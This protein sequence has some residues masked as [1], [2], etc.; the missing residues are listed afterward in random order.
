MHTFAE[1][2]A[3]YREAAACFTRQAQQAVAARGRFVVAL[4][5]G[6]T[7]RGLYA[8]LAGAPYRAAVAWPRTH[9]FW[10]DERCVPAGDS[11]R[12]ARM[13]R[14]ALLDHVPVPPAQVHP[15]ECAADPEQAARQYAAQLRDFFA[16]QPPVFDL[17]LLGLGADGHT[18][19]LLPHSP[20]LQDQTAWTAAV[21]PQAPDVPRVTLMPAVINRARLVVFLVAGQEK[22]AALAAVCHGPPDPQ[23]LPAQ[24]VRPPGGATVWLVDE[25]AGQLP[26]PADP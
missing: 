22:A 12:N 24:L 4:S 13:A 17:I 18:A 23:R 11:R 1:T 15:I 2:E 5:G 20:I 3:L 10:G 9:F 25:A 7:P 21:H 26:P 6:R 8:R 16:G 19:S 14:E